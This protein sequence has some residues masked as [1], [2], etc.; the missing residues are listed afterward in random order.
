MRKNRALDS[1]FPRTRQAIL[2]ATLIQPD[3]WWYLTDLAKH[4]GLRPS[5]I[6]RELRALVGAGI[7]RRR[8]DGNRVYFQPDPECPFL[9]EL[10]GLLAKTAGLA[11]VLREALGPFAKRIE[12]AFVFGS[13][14][15]SDEDSR[16]DIDLMVVGDIGL[17]DLAPVLRPVEARLGRPMNP[18]VL[19]RAELLKKL[20]QRNHFVRKVLA[21]E[22]LFV[23]GRED[24]LEAAAGE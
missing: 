18:V 2:G 12:W 13:I 5:S 22:K 23:L 15:R 19:R 9:A 8:R 1:L 11:D 17:S 24:E 6:Q 3:R 20:R 21:G 14:A 4:L 7:L 10:Q 16:S